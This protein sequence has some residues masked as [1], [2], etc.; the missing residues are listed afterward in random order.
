MGGDGAGN[1]ANRV[2]GVQGEGLEGEGFRGRGSGG[3]VQGEGFRGRVSGGGFQ[4][5]KFMGKGGVSV[6]A[7]RESARDSTAGPRGADCPGVR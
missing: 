2:G 1:A 3:G 4:G 7:H 6:D 5:G